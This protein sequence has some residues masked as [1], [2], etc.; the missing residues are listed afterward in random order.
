MECPTETNILVGHL[1]VTNSLMHTTHG[2]I[3]LKCLYVILKTSFETPKLHRAGSI[4]FLD[5]LGLY[6]G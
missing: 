1:N 5:L 4:R 3:P 2:I 6:P